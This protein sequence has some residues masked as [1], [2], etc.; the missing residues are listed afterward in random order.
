MMSSAYAATHL[1]PWNFS[2]PTRTELILWRISGSIF[3]G[4]KVLFCM[5][6]TV[7][8]RQRFGRWDKYLIALRLM[9]LP[10]CA[11]IDEEKGCVVP[12]DTVKRLDA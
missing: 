7:A 11:P 1:I 9:E 3:T 8:A 5:F 12:Q 4:V 2:F 6:E 10:L